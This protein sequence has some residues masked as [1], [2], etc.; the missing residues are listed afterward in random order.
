[1]SDV[2]AV[3]RDNLGLQCT[4]AEALIQAGRF[5]QALKV[6]SQAVQLQPDSPLALQMLAEAQLEKDLDRAE[7]TTTRI[8]ELAPSHGAGYDL[9]GRI[10][11]KRGHYAA[12][13]SHFREALRKE[14]G[15]SGYSNNLGLALR[16]QHRDKAAVEAF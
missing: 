4:Y 9:R 7:A 15:N 3:D 2:V 13:E 6:A 11:L 8:L 1:M 16:H 5:D 14:P 10:A 12:A